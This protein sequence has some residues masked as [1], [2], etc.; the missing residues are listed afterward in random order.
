ME[1]NN[2]MKQVIMSLYKDLQWGRKAS[3]GI[4]TLVE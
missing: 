2:Q 1:N 3:A 4:P